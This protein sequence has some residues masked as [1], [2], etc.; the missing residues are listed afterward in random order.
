MLE[1]PA[2]VER[3]LNWLIIFFTANADPNQKL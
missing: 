3:F 2:A 1:M